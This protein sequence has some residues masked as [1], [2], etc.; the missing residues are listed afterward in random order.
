MR[1]LLPI[2]LV[3]FS[4][5]TSSDYDGVSEE[6]EDAVRDHRNIDWQIGE[7]F[8]ICDPSLNFQQCD[9]GNNKQRTIGI[10][11]LVDAVVL[12]ASM[13]EGSIAIEMADV[14]VIAD[15]GESMHVSV[16]KG[17]ET[18]LTNFGFRAAVRPYGSDSEWI[19]LPQPSDNSDWRELHIGSSQG[20]IE[21]VEV[22]CTGEELCVNT[23]KEFAVD[24]LARLERSE[25]ELLE[26]RFLAYPIAEL[27]FWDTLYLTDE[28]DL[29]LY[30][31]QF[32]TSYSAD[33]PS[34]N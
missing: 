34:G 21:G 6:R 26:Y 8:G 29:G 7:V 16:A 31:F 10:G 33:S 22:A 9:R 1:P 27:D 12:S 2:L 25:G 20:L 3:L 5:C 19:E 30:Q 13:R 18:P 24:E 17:L 4:G 11:S 32:R 23:P 28:F 15:A 14:R